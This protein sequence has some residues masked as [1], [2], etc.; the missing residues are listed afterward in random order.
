MREA[1]G[2]RS[3]STSHHVG[4]PDEPGRKEKV[5]LK[6]PPGFRLTPVADKSLTDM[7]VSG[8]LDALLVAQPP[9]HYLQGHPNVTRMFEDYLGV[10]RAYVEKTKIIPIMHTVAVRKTVLDQ[11][12]WV[13]GNLLRAFTEAK[14]R[15]VERMFYA[16]MTHVPILWCFEHAR[17]QASLFDGEYWPYGVEG[18]RHT[19]GVF[20]RYAFEQGVCHRLLEVEELF[21]KQVLSSYRV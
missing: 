4:S 19:L 3:A 9:R 21:P 13:A 5:A 7:L 2:R 18:N 10:E 20:L 1:D 15:S 6:L 8:E 17:R 11:H 16:G 12:P 14:D